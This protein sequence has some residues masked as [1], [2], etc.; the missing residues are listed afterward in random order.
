MDIQVGTAKSRLLIDAATQTAYLVPADITW[1]DG[2]IRGAMTV[3]GTDGRLVARKITLDGPDDFDA[4][5]YIRGPQLRAVIKEARRR[6][7]VP[8]RVEDDGRLTIQTDVSMMGQEDNGRRRWRRI[9]PEFLEAVAKVYM[10]AKE[11]GEP[12][13]LAVIEQF[14]APRNTVNDWLRRARDEGFLPPVER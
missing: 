8:L 2:D 3:T 9:T 5:D 6:L 13:A 11:A 12:P 14:D 10:D 7:E 1:T 4:I